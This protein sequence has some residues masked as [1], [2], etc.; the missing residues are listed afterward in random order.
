MNFDHLRLRSKTFASPVAEHHE[1]VTQLYVN[2]SNIC[3][4]MRRVSV[5]QVIGTVITV[6]SCVRLES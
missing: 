5:D 4:S 1:M 2:Y 6:I 3:D